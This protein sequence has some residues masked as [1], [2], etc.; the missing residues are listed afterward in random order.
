MKVYLYIFYFLQSLTQGV[1]LGLLMTLF[2]EFY[3]F[4]ILIQGMAPFEEYQIKEKQ[5][6]YYQLAIIEKA[7]QA[8]LSY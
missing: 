2:I 6:M 3:A 4:F 8:L 7:D 5:K 1:Y